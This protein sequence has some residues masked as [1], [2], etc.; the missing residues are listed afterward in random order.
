MAFGLDLAGYSTGRSALSVIE[1][2]G[3]T[4]RAI[5][6]RR[7][8]F[9]TARHGCEDAE[10]IIPLE[11]EALKTCLKFGPVAVDVPIDLEG[12]PAPPDVQFLWQLTKRT[13]DEA[14]E[15]L[16]P[17]ADRLGAPV[18]RFRATLTAAHLWDTLG[19]DLFETY[20]SATLDHFGVS[21]SGYKGRNKR[22]EQLGISK[23]LRLT[24]C[25]DEDALDAIICAMAALPNNRLGSQELLEIVQRKN[26]F[27]Q[28]TRKGAT[29]PQGYILAR[30]IPFQAIEVVEATFTEWLAQQASSQ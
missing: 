15:A 2:L 19:T 26:P 27:A 18:A 17:L 9:S 16:P 3:A 21:T 7:S 22:N 11:A 29:V 30:T 10:G 28:Y 1:P 5:I 14:F 4:A 24:S 8:P 13:V 23:A 25:P 6:L 20:P 12:L